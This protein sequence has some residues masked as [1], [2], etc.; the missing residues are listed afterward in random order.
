MTPQKT[1][2]II[3]GG[4]SGALV[5]INL[6]RQQTATPLT[7]KWIEKTG[8]F[9]TGIAYSTD[10]DY[11]LLNVPANAMGLYHD[12]PTHFHE[13]LLQNGY[14]YSEHDYVPRKIYAGYIQEELTHYLKNN[15]NSMVHLLHGEVKDIESNHNGYW[16]ILSNNKRFQSDEIVIA[17]GNTIPLPPALRDMTYTQHPSYHNNPWEK[18]TNQFIRRNDDILLIGTGLTTVDHLLD[19]Y[20]QDHK[21]NIYALSRNG[22]LPFTHYP[23]SRHQQYPDYTHELIATSDISKIYSIIR[24][25]I[26]KGIKAGIDWRIVLDTI[27][28]TLPKIWNS[29]PLE[30]KKQ[31]HKRLHALWNVARHRIP[32]L[33]ADIIHSMKEK[34]QLR[35]LGGRIAEIR[36]TGNEFE[37]TYTSRKSGLQETIRVQK[38]INCSGPPFPAHDNSPLFKNLRER[39]MLCPDELG[40]GWNATADGRI[41]NREQE[42]ITG[43]YTI[44]SGLKGILFES[45][46]LPEL[47]QQAYA[48]AQLINNTHAKVA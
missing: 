32:V 37:V 46:A 19:L 1:I 36:N 22:Y 47:R 48:L 44:G 13:W 25:H 7:I 39:S 16:V 33:C 26:R 24:Q 6:L 12:R 40:I 29:L 35:I 28:P 27:R 38:I 5:L 45:T 14:Q 4:L 43:L 41:M 20:H 17:T 10:K 8:E 34:K 11:H 23:C 2:S 9:G 15:R 21:G 30:Q 31:F 18:A 42:I 3:G